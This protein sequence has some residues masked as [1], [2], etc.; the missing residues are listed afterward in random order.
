[1]V[2]GP[3][4]EIGSDQ[5]QNHRNHRRVRKR[6]TGGKEKKTTQRRTMGE[7]KKKTGHLEHAV[8]ETG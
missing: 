6:D 1:M 3:D 4:K 7:R 2:K 8:I 5:K